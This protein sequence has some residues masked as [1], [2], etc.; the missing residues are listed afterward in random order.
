MALLATQEHG[1]DGSGVTPVAA[2]GGGDTMKLD[3]KTQLVLVNGNVSSR[4]VTITGAVLCNQGFAHDMVITAAG[5]A[6]TRSPVLDP[7]R[8][9][10]TASIAYSAVTDLTVAAV[11]IT[12]NQGLA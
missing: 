7:D 11:R 3:G 5:N 9:G 1:D 8:F 4:T 10:S 12:T 6:T 2:A